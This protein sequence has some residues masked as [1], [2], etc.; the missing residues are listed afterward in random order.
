MRNLDRSR[1]QASAAHVHQF[2]LAKQQEELESRRQQVDDLWNQ[3]NAS[4]IELANQKEAAEKSA[5]LARKRKQENENLLQRLMNAIQSRN[6]MRGRLGNMTMQR[7][8]A[9]RQVETLTAQNREVMTELKHTTDKL[10]EAYQQVGAL[11]V[12]YEQDMAE[13]AQAYQHVDLKQRA[14]LPEKLKSLLDQMEQDY[15]GGQP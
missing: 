2:N 13:L 11:Q 10:G 6:S 14:H 5:A 9:I 15:T 1:H 3:L 8:R 12:D 4:D 7:N